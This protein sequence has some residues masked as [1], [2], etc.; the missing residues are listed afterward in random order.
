MNVSIVGATGHTNVVV[1]GVRRDDDID[2][3]G[4]APG[5][6]GKS[7]AELHDAVREQNPDANRYENAE[8]LLKATDPD[9]VVSACYFGDLASVTRRALDRGCHV[10]TE[11]PVATTVDDL[12]AVMA[13][14]ERSDAELAAMLGNRYDPWFRTAHARVNEGALGEVRLLDARKSYKLGTRDEPYLSRTS[15]GGTI[16]WVGIHAIDWFNWFT[17]SEFRSVRSL[18]STERNRGHGDLEVTAVA[19]FELTGEVFASLAVDYLRPDEAPT[20]GDDRLRVV[21]TEGVIEVRDDQVFLVDSEAD[22]R[23]RLPL[24]ETRGAFLDF[25]GQLRGDSPCLVSAA[26]SFRATEASLM[27]RRAADQRAVVHFD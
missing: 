1:E 14:Y 12:D 19:E 3:V 20:R 8:C 2:V 7:V 27:A 11:K 13:A 15:S 17:G 24:L 21:G 6:D 5:S 4:V 10:Y 26:D 22:G 18:H 23:R 16:P 9:V 25:V